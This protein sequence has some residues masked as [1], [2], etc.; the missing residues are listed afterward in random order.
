[1]VLLAA[2][3]LIVRQDAELPRL[4]DQLDCRLREAFA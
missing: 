2:A 3:I 1:M 4:V